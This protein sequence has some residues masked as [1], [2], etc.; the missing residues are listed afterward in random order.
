MKYYH[1]LFVLLLARFPLMAQADNQAKRVVA[2]LHL[3]EPEA[4]Q[5][6]VSAHYDSLNR[7]FADRT[8]AVKKAEAA[9]TRELASARGRSAWDAGN[10]KLNKLHAIFLGRLSI[11]LTADQL[12]QLKNSMTEGGLQREY[13]NF[14]DLLP[15]LSAQQKAQVMTY[16]KEAR[17]NAMIAET[18]HAR[19]EWFIKYR[20]RTN[21]YLAAAGYDLR[22]A[23]EELEAKKAATVK[24]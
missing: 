4:V 17:E 22:K 6:L 21:N 23:T 16:L 20:G 19:N 12:E 1:L 8:V 3:T 11:L 9:E 24:K 5:K 7:V 15:K 13:K 2:S 10:G 18:A 14:L